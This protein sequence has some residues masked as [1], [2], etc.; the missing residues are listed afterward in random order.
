[1]KHGKELPFTKGGA[2]TIVWQMKANLPEIQV[3]VK[4]SPKDMGGPPPNV[5][6]TLLHKYACP[7]VAAG[8]GMA[9]IAKA[10]KVGLEGNKKISKLTPHC[11]GKSH[12]PSRPRVHLFLENL[13]HL[14]LFPRSGQDVFVNSE[15]EHSLKCYYKSTTSGEVSLSID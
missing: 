4:G 15:G 2:S 3:K 12:A 8:G 7:C 6:G 13:L 9:T 10:S 11:P 1:M 5:V 14:E